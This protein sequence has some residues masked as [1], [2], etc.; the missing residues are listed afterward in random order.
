MFIAYLIWN[1]H[2]QKF[3]PQEIPHGMEE[4]VTFF[5]INFDKVIILVV[6]INSLD[7]KLL[8]IG[9]VTNQPI[10]HS[11]NEMDWTYTFWDM[12]KFIRRG[13]SFLEEFISHVYFHP[14]VIKLQ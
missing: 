12:A 6:K 2:L 14:I 9:R 5:C 4:I 7:I 8:C 1:W 10:F 13:L 11:L 3:E